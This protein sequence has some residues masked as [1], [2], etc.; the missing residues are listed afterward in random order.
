MDVLS[1]WSSVVIVPMRF[2]SRAQDTSCRRSSLLFS[3]AN[4]QFFN[5]VSSD[6]DG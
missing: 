3:A 5:D 1:L 4:P 6:V 2:E